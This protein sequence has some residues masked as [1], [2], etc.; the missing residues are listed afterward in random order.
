MTDLQGDKIR[1]GQFLSWL[2]ENPR[3][4][5]PDDD[6]TRKPLLMVVNPDIFY[7][8][9][10][11]AY[12]QNDRLPLYQDFLNYFNFIIVDEFHYY[13]P[14]QFANFLF[15][16]SLSDYYGLFKSANRQF[17]L[18][19]ATPATQVADY[20]DKLGLEIDWI[21]PDN[22]DLSQTEPTPALA[23]VELEIYSSE[24]FD[25]R[26]GLVALV[27]HKQGQL[28]NWLTNDQHGAIISSALWKI[29]QIHANLLPAVGSEKMGRLTGP[30]TT[31]GR[32][33]AKT[34][35][36]ILATPT[37][38]IGYNFERP[39]KDRQNID[40]LLFDARFGDEFIQRLGRAGRVLGK[41]VQN[42]SSQVIALV[43]PEFYALLKPFDKQ[44]LDRLRLQELANQLPDRHAFYSYIQNGAMV[45]AYKTL[46]NEKQP[47]SDAARQEHQQLYSQIKQLFDSK[48]PDKKLEDGMKTFFKRQA[49][50]GRIKDFPPLERGSIN[51]WYKLCQ[52][53]DDAQQSTK[54][55][56]EFLRG[57]FGLNL[58]AED[59]FKYLLQD[60]ACYHA[61][62]ARYNFREAFQPPSVLVSDTKHLF[63]S[64]DITLGDALQIARNYK[65]YYFSSL[66]EWLKQLKLEIPPE[67]ADEARA[68]LA[69]CDLSEQRPVEERLK[70]QFELELSNLF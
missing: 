5:D 39:G 50:Y 16:M 48:I 35:S 37:V 21:K 8:A 42:R 70:I 46:Y 53:F 59:F 65:A 30:E 10:T 22:A 43:S 6:G 29:N 69:F 51:E 24:E 68:A 62:K 32:N 1:R 63:T 9:L 25:L 44:S 4:I 28:I 57:K 45:E 67:L 3:Q 40:F 38:D 33:A 27:R 11:F 55:H 64:A 19:T 31:S 17:C 7:Y 20:L 66:N 56:I 14:K 52:K 2:I 60:I 18:L 41:T 26:E 58:K 54:K 15:F 12:N 49:A 34:K 61:E 23:S 36:L 47:M 13:N